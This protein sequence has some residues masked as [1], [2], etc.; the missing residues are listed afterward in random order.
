MPKH[1]FKGESLRIVHT[2]EEHGPHPST[3]FDY[4]DD[5][6]AITVL[7]QGEAVCFVEGHAY[8]LRP[9]DLVVLSPDEIRSFRFDGEG[10]HERLSLYFSQAILSAL[11]DSE[12]PLLAVFGAHPSGEGNLIRHEEY[13]KDAMARILED[14]CTFADEENRVSMRASRIQL[15]ILSLLFLLYDARKA[16]NG[17][18]GVERDPDI[19]R[20]CRYVTT[21]LEEKLTL[22]E[23][24]KALFLSRYQLTVAFARATGMSLSEYILH[25]RLSHAVAAIRKG[26]PLEKAAHEAGFV[27]YSYFFKAFRRRYGTSPRAYFSGER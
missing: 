1:E 9:G 14:L 27:S 17:G 10:V 3:P 26:T 8:T 25:K 24:Q 16:T 18:A 22:A 11:W 6:L 4:Y 20:V 19:Q 12:L 7:L 21:H 13:R 2:L 5:T 15:S 23:L